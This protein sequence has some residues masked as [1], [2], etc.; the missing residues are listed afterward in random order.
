MI[1]SLEVLAPSPSAEEAALE[2]L[3][4]GDREGALTLLMAAFGTALYRFC[5]QMVVDP[6]LAADVHQ[7]TF[8]QAFEGFDRFQPGT[9]LKAWLF[10][11]ARHRCLDAVKTERRR[12][13]RFEATDELPEPPAGA[14][15]APTAETRLAA[16]H[17]ASAL[18][19][20]LGELAPA[21]RSAVLLRFQD[22]LSY[23]EMETVCRERPATLQARVARALPVLRRCLEQRGYTP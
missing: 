3:E 10:G 12:R 7:T 1:R 14:A 20:C 11:I 19:R 17:L 5:R 2:A 21:I 22:G 23:P 6:D 18:A 16:R 4:R 9:S 13:A 8:V 15:G